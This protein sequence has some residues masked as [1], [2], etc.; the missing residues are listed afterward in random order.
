[1][2]VQRESSVPV[3]Q[4]IVDNILTTIRDKQMNKG[5]RFPTEYELVEK[6]GVSRATIRKAIAQLVDK[7]VII[8]SPGKGMFVKNPIIEMNFNELRGIYEILEMQ[9]LKTDSELV[10]YVKTTPPP[11]IAENLNISDDELIYSIQRVYYIDNQPLAFSTAYLNSDIEF[12]NSDIED[13]KIY[14]ILQKKMNIKLEEATYK[15]NA[16]APTEKLNEIL[17]NKSNSPFL[18]M[19]RITYCVN[20]IPREATIAYFT[21]DKYQ[22]NF[23]I[24]NNGEM[25]L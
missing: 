11:S 5:D 13:L 7:D 14:G 15:I 10:E 3:Y 25:L 21:S 22:F 17:D 20:Q 18:K 2:V 12:T 1:M 24:T 8:V 16:S 9:G 4:Q 23:N 19:E 6:Y